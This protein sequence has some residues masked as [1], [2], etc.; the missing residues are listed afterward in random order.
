[1]TVNKKMQPYQL[2][3]FILLKP[4]TPHSINTLDKVLIHDYIH[5]NVN[6]EEQLLEFND[7]FNKMFL[8]ENAGDISNLIQI[9]Y[10]EYLFQKTYNDS[11]A[12]INQLM[13]LILSLS[14]RI[15]YQEQKLTR[16]EQNLKVHFDEIRS[17]IYNDHFFPASI[18]EAADSVFLS[19]SRFA[20]LYRKFFNVSPK[21]DILLAQIQYAKE[22]LLTTDLSIREIA[23]KCRFSNEYAFIRSFKNHVNISP[24]KWR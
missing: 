1:M 11:Q 18:K 17:A 20:H 23:E 9:I 24:G 12:I 7:L 22:M 16:N 4:Q 21:Q 6:D 14:S 3:S 13:S 8:C 15:S 10:K 2:N 19:E 5:F